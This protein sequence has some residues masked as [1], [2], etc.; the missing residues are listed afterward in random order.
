[1]L[2]LKTTPN[3]CK[4]LIR[5]LTYGLSGTALAI[6]L[7]GPESLQAHAQGATPA[8]N[9]GQFQVASNTL[10]HSIFEPNYQR[11]KPR[12]RRYASRRKKPRI[13]KVSPKW[14]QK[15]NAKDPVQIIVSLPERRLTVYRGD[16]EVVSSRV[17]TGRKGFATPSG[18]FSIL[19]KNIDHRS[20]IFSGVPMPYMQRLTWSGIALHGFTSVPRVPASAGCIR[21]PMAFASQLFKYTDRGAHVIVA[22]EKT[23]PVVIENDNLIRPVPRSREV[24]A[25]LEQPEGTVLSDAETKAEAKA[26]KRAAAPLRILITRRSVKGRIKEVQTLLDE[27]TFEP[28]DIDGWMGPD[29]AKSIKRFQATYGL[30][31]NGL[32]SDELV[33]RLYEVA[34]KDKPTNGRLYV[35]QNFKPVFDAQV[36]IRNEEQTLGTHLFTAMYFEPDATQAR[37]TAVTL[38]KGSPPNRHVLHGGLVKQPLKGVDQSA[39]ALEAA[40]AEEVLNRIVIPDETRQRLAKLLTPGSS[41]AISDD[42]IS[43]ETSPKSGSDFIVLMQ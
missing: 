7:M 38:K 3:S 26:R 1:M 34:E 24:L 29:T 17:S 37:W 4:A 40:T 41:I 27:L 10:L 15:G 18:M 19:Q 30:K 9:T 11:P 2:M 23:A 35:R 16:Q 21:L 33:D 8:S 32:I 28:G 20:N 22:N 43:W 31:A 14:F 39:E 13:P 36:V 42:G 6:V 5:R 12:A 25:S